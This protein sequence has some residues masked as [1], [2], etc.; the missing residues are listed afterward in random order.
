MSKSY[1]Y[2]GVTPF[3]T[4]QKGLFFGRDDDSE[5]LYKLVMRQNFVVLHGKSGFGKTSLINAG[6]LP[7]IA[8]Q[9]MFEAVEVRF[10]ARADENRTSPLVK[11]KAAFPDKNKLLSSLLKGD[12]SLWTRAKA[13]Q[14]KTGRFPLIIFDQFEE[15]FTYPQ[16]EVD[17]FLRDLI[18]L[19]SD[20][21]PLRYWR[22]LEKSTDLE[23][24]EE[25]KVEA[26][27]RVHV[28]LSMRSD[29]LHLL[30]GFKKY[31]S[32]LLRH[33]FRLQ[34]F[35]LEAARLAIE[36]PA[37]L[38]GDYESAPF[39][40][41]PKALRRL[42]TYLQGDDD[43]G[44]IEGILIQLLCEHYERKVVIPKRV[45]EITTK[46]L[47]DP[48]RVVR[49]YY[50][51]K[52]R[53]LPIEEQLPAQR[54]IEEGLVSGGKKG[55][56]L[57]LHE[58]I[59]E[60]QYHIDKDLLAKLVNNRLLRSEPFLRGGYSYEL[61]HDRLIPAV[62]RARS[63]R[64]EQ[65]EITKRKKETKQLQEKA[66]RE[67]LA[68]ERARSQLRRVQTYLGLA[69]LALVAAA[70]LGASLISNAQKLKAA[71]TAIV[72]EQENVQVQFQRYLES[73]KVR[74]EAEIKRL[75]DR[76]TTF[77]A[78]NQPDLSRRSR[79]EAQVM[80]SLRT[81]IMLE[82]QQLRKNEQ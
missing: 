81:E 52:I 41:E 66:E 71:N 73:E 22:S 56:R 37:A 60:S 43:E 14:L 29:R 55:L 2:P 76:A 63:E 72:K 25:E 78:L 51:E 44:R 34:A 40:F 8:N 74:L 27:L 10:G 13:M 7:R 49:K 33:S 3:T 59:I 42:E 47:G 6:L 17:A 15:I 23:E 53:E 12:D 50:M 65:E 68:K 45:T 30:E 11:T 64:L 77:T 28:L 38:E 46:H 48:R 57:S 69:I 79:E 32:N 24:E 36:S 70:I 5:Q 16:A 67:R 58:A 20:D 9:E 61:S 75:E 18:E 26:P 31:F 1:R 80:D 39:T 21:L 54:L 19:T 4:E 82:L 62:V 35:S